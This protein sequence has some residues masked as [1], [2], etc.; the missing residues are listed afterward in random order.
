VSGKTLLIGGATIAVAASVAT[1]FLLKVFS[2]SGEDRPPIIV[3]NGSVKIDGGNP[4][5][6]NWKPWKQHGSKK[7]WQPDHGNGA[8]TTN[9]SVGIT[10]ANGPAA[11]SNPCPSLPLVGT[12][13]RVEYTT[14]A[15]VKS[16]VVIS[17][18]TSGSNHIPQINA[19]SDM[20]Q[21]AGSGNTPDQIVYDPGAGFISN[22]I[23]SNDS[24]GQQLCG[25]VKPA[26]AVITIQPNR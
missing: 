16:E 24:G 1:V 15:G 3:R 20:A 11:P 25:F 7:E 17:I 9:F 2:A 5:S 10:S 6:T 4:N 13:V 8:S 12:K 18:D 23:V 19:P 21:H 14:D 22:V 26:S